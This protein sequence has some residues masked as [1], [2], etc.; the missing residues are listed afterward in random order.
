MHPLCTRCACHAF[1][2][3]RWLVLHAHRERDAKRAEMS[4]R[5]GGLEEQQRQLHTW[6]AGLVSRQHE[7]E[8][9]VKQV[10]CI[11]V[12]LCMRSCNMPE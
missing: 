8:A 7:I 4:A 2:K 1:T 6:Q 12:L 3:T 5:E 9:Y 10:S 11:P